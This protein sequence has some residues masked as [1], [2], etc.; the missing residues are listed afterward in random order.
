MKWLKAIKTPP[1]SLILLCYKH[2]KFVAEAID[3][4]LAQTYAPLEIIV[5]D[6]CSPDRTGD[7]IAAKL[8]AHP[9]G[10]KI[11]FIRNP[12]NLGGKS[13]AEIGL[14]RTTGNFV[15]IVSGDDVMLPEMVAEM[16]GV[17]M[18]EDVSLVAANAMYIDANSNA[19]GRTFRDP[20]TRADDSFETLA[21]DGANACCFGPAMAFEREV[22]ATFGWPPLYLGTYDIMFPYY[23]HLLKGARF[24]EKP[25]LKYR[26]HAGNTSLSLIEESGDETRRL[27]MRE[28]MYFGHLAHAL[29]MQEELRRLKGEQRERYAELAERIAPLLT[30]QITEMGRKLVNA[31]IDLQR[32]GT[33]LDPGHFG[34]LPK[35]S[36]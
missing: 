22:Y 14:R 32:I 27:L 2:E 17:W 3:G 11:P 25:L 8:A 29:L 30:V 5:I 18:K 24:I 4:V 12:H 7:I 35:T 34:I 10:L 6:D 15:F 16:A 9:A 23:A 13:S 20:T 26:V 28:R 33:S 36:E 1:I 31:R 21:R 19:L